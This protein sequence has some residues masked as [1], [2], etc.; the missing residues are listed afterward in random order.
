VRESSPAVAGGFVYVGSW[1]DRVYCLNATTGAFVWSYMTDQEVWSSPAVVGGLV[2]VGSLDD[3]VHCLNATTGA[4]VWSYETGSYVYSSP[5]VVNGVVYVGSFDDK[6]YAFGAPCLHFGQYEVPVSTTGKNVTVS[7]SK[8][9]QVTFTNVTEIGV[10]TMNVTQ[11]TSNTTTLTAAPNSMLVSVKTNATYVGNV[12]LQ[13]TY[14]QTGLTL[15]DQEAMKIWLWNTTSDKW[16]DITTSVD[17]VNHIVYGVSPH[18]SMFGITSSLSVVSDSV[19]I[20]TDV[21]YLYSLPSSYSALPDD[22]QAVVYFNMSTTQPYSGPCTIRA[23]Y[24]SSFILPQEAQFMRMWLWN[25]TS[26]EWVD[27]TVQVDTVNSVIY[28]VSPHLSMFGIT[29]LPSFPLGIVVAGK[30]TCSK[31]VVG[32]GFNVSITMPI[33]NQGSTTETFD[34]LIYANYTLIG[35]ELVSNLQPSGQMNMTFTYTAGLAYGNY[36]ISVCGQP[37]SWLK[38]TIPGDVNGDG[39]VNSLDVALIAAHWLQTVPPAP[40]NADILSD[41]IINSQDIAVIAANWLK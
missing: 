1:D 8:Y 20:K 3:C 15:Q 40:A 39:F 10:L 2:Y 33:G 37:I 7:P 4:F 23:A 18:L 5:A 19:E 17:T 32:K 21:Q 27:I 11:P 25:T 35:T 12:T 22:L 13:F 26:R 34:A 36:S 9:A 38:I 24:N 16:V 14:N 28:G 30:A 6:I 31:T 29:C 41:G